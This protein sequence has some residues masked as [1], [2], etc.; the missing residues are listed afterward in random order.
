MALNPVQLENE[1]RHGRLA[2][3]AALIGVAL[4]IASLVLGS[5]F[6]AAERAERLTEWDSFSGDVLL[7]SILQGIAALLFAPGLVVLFRAAQARNEAVRPG[8]LGVVVGGPVLLAISFIA[9]YFAYDAASTAFLGSEFDLTSSDAADDVFYEQFAT[10]LVTGFGLAGSL[11]VVFGIVYS[12]LQAMRVG[13]MT[14]FFGTLGMALGVGTVLFG[15]PMLLLFMLILSLLLT[16]WWPGTL[17]P[18]WEAGKAVPW[19]TPGKPGDAEPSKQRPADPADFEGSGREV[20]SA[21]AGEGASG[22]GAQKRKKKK[23]R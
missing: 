12:S 22:E 13:L 10:Q 19:P 17:P 7:Q 15:P 8:F 1:Q 21:G 9:T 18:A 16:R 4:F 11:G 2:G 3:I 23:K 20:E 14:R 6:T 5:D